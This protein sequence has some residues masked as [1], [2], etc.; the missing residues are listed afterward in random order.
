MTVGG[1]EVLADRLA[2]NMADRYETVFACL[3]DIGALG[4]QL[5]A[6][7]YQVEC[8]G[9]RSG[10]DLR[11]AW[12][13][14]RLLQKYHIDLVVAHQYT[15][16]FYGMTA[17][18]FGRNRPIVFVEH[19]RSFP[20]YPRPKRMMFNRWMVRRHDRLIAVGNDVR[21]ALVENEGLPPE[22]VEVIY[23]GVDLN[24]FQPDAARRLKNRQE[25]DVASKAF[26]IT[27]VAR[28]DALK[29]HLTAV[30][31]MAELVKSVPHARL[32]IVGDGPERESIEAEIEKLGLREHIRVLGLRKDVPRILSASDA[33]LLTSVSEGIPLTLIEG[34]GAG[35]PI[36]TTDVGGIR[37]VVCEDETALMAP[38]GDATLLAKHLERFARDPDLRK[39]FGD[40]GYRLAHEK[41]SEEVMHAQYARVYDEVLGMSSTSEDPQK[42]LA[43]V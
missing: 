7:G 33:M 5:Q 20:D 24:P 40:G 8:L 23:N 16:F 42:E 12:R 13:L 10:V 19:G 22:R 11:C 41:F 43:R 29:D 26:V 6:D 17:R 39:Q 34:M 4:Q 28:L 25:L 9:R 30:R 35:L 31:T 27:Q 1:A 3:D 32:L 37:E 38:A 14:A 18:L 36:V 15:P 2:R 21:R